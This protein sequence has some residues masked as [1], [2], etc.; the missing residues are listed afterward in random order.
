MPKATPSFS[1]QELGDSLIARVQSLMQVPFN[2]LSKIDKSERRELG[3]RRCRETLS[4]VPFYRNRA[5]NHPR[6][7]ENY[8]TSLWMSHVNMVHPPVESSTPETPRHLEW[9]PEEEPQM[10]E[11]NLDVFRLKI[12]P[13]VFD[14]RVIDY[15][16]PLVWDDEPPQT[17]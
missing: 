4:C 3:W 10:P 6:G 7:E 11:Q 17:T 1:S 5:Q 13:S 2:E 9:P 12:K 14:T 8:W 16:H 15:P